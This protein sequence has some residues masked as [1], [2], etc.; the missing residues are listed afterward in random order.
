MFVFYDWSFSLLTCVLWVWKNVAYFPLI[1]GSVFSDCVV[2]YG[3]SNEERKN[4]HRERLFHE[5]KILQINV[6]T[7]ECDFAEEQNSG[8]CSAT[9]LHPVATSHSFS[10]FEIYYNGHILL[11][12]WSEPSRDIQQQVCMPP[13]LNTGRVWLTWTRCC[14]H[15][16]SGEWWLRSF[17]RR[18]WFTISPRKRSICYVRLVV[19]RKWSMSWKTHRVCFSERN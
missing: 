14:C 5:Y 16:M 2:F 12:L 9:V 8:K 13:P 18:Q 10:A 3:D 11:F 4:I 7:Q 19:W 6:R 17:K 1:L 15:W